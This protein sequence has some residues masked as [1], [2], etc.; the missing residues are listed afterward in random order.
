MSGNETNEITPKRKHKK[1]DLQSARTPAKGRHRTGTRSAVRQTASGLTALPMPTVSDGT[2]YGLTLD[3][4]LADLPLYRFTVQADCLGTQLAEVFAQH[5]LLP[6]VV[7]IQGQSSSNAPGHTQGD[8]LLGMVSRQ[9]LLEYLIRPHGLDLFLNEPLHVLYSY[10]RC[11]VLSF[12]AD[13]SILVAAPQALRRSPDLLGEPL[14]VQVSPDDYCILDIHTLHIAYW[15]I[16]G[17]ETQVRYERTQAQLIRADKMANLGN[18]VDGVAHE[19]LDP[20]SFI[21]GNLSHISSYCRDLLDV[22]A[23]YEQ[24]LPSPPDELV[25]LLDILEVDY[26]KQDLPKTIDS[27]RTGADRLS[28]LASSLQNFCHI[29]DVY[30][31]PVNL[32]ELLDSIILLLKSHLSTEIQVVK[33]YGALPPVSCY[34]GQLN[35]VFMNILSNATD[36]LLNQAVSQRLQMGDSLEVGMPLDVSHPI[37]PTIV[38]TTAVRS[39]MEGD[40]ES[41]WVLV[42]I[43]NNGPGLPP[44][45]YQRLKTAFSVERRA[46]KETSLAVSYQIITAKHGGKFV[47]RT[48][49]LPDLITT[50]QNP[51]VEFEILLP[52]A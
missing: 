30:P 28:K 1:Q 42:S 32:H 49:Q 46:M 19:I 12:T 11:P 48:P 22:I 31:K 3:S 14:L 16:R 29:D 52:L 5:P 2:R 50:E 47:V 44:E 41:R 37:P 51:G 13:T 40:R 21:W 26:I 9:R 35:Q 17:L 27:V 24:H 43:A 10:A 36:A 15:Q 8:R 34:A 45:T 23:A 25:H 20:V 7:L 18:L 38:I 33:H 39:Q 4:T 6:G